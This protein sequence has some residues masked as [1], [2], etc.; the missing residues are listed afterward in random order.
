MRSAERRT[1]ASLKDL[2]IRYKPRA[3]L[4]L[5]VICCGLLSTTCDPSGAP[6]PATR[7]I[8]RPS[9]PP[10][11]PLT[12]WIESTTARLSYFHHGQQE[13]LS[14]CA[15]FFSDVFCPRKMAKGI[16]RRV[17][18]RTKAS[19]FL[20]MKQSSVILKTQQNGPRGVL[21]VSAVPSPIFKVAA[22][23]DRRISTVSAVTT[24]QVL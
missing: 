13:H 20:E 22:A 7:C 21:H 12:N 6:L 16:L 23:Q 24:W 19:T 11:C 18:T 9:H 15:D 17:E 4:A 1:K 3:A 2:H 10:L 5:Q 14:T 8:A